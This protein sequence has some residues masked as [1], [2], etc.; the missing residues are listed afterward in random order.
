MSKSE[1]VSYLSLLKDMILQ[2]VKDN[3]KA[4]IVDE[5]MILSLEYAIKAVQESEVN[6]YE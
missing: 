6:Y 1:T 3:K 2:N 4:T 5:K